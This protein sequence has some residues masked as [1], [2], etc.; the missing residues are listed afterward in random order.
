RRFRT[1]QLDH[2]DLVELM[3][4]FDPAHV[5]PR[6]HLLAPKAR[7]VRGQVNR[8]TVLVER[9]IAMQARQWNLG[10][11]DKPEIILV[12]VV[13]RVRVLRQMPGTGGRLAT[14]HQRRNYFEITL[15]P[16]DV[17]HPRNQRA[18]EPRA[19]TAQ[20]IEPRPRQ[21]HPAI[22]IDDPKILAQFPMRQWLERSELVR[23]T[24]GLDDA[25][26]RLARANDNI[27]PRNVGQCERQLFYSLLRKAEL[28]AK[29]QQRIAGIDRL[30]LGK[31]LFIRFLGAN[32]R[33]L[34][35][36][37]LRRQLADFPRA[38]LA[39]RSQLIDLALKLAALL[40]SLEQSIDFGGLD[41]SL[42]EFALYEIGPFTN[43]L[44]IQH[45]ECV[46]QQFNLQPLA[47]R[48]N[49]HDI[50]AHL[51][52]VRSITLRKS[53]RRAPHPLLLALI[54]GLLGRTR[55][56]APP[57]FHLDEHQSVAVH[58][59]EID[60]GSR[61]AKIPRDDPVT[62]PAQML[63]SSA[64]PAPSKRKLYSKRCQPRHGPVN[65]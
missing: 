37:L 42:G 20:N 5:A 45:S 54:D 51:G 48:V 16:L 63:L 17:E 18:L 25:V 52:L 58:R 36:A 38:P 14:N 11:R 55:R 32:L 8:Q 50:K 15:L 47:R 56:A 64:L 35:R 23:R 7:R 34:S 9:L 49:R 31:S 10:G 60:L 33:D 43:Q 24:L 65:R 1:H 39:I 61:R 40:I 27:R 4:A 26:I 21:F 41:P 30:T 29:H 46:P 12:V 19:G 22:E 57:S 44:N 6:R 59:D 13:H 2:L 28:R 53:F 3:P 62:V